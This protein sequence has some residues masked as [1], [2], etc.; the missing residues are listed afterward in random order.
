[1]RVMRVTGVALLLALLLAA[2]GAG[3]PEGERSTT[4]LRL[5]GRASPTGPAAA[6]ESP[7][8]LLVRGGAVA[9]AAAELER[10]GVPV[11][12]W[13]PGGGLLVAGAAPAVEGLPGV[14]AELAWGPDQAVAPEL[15]AATPAQAAARSGGL[16]VVLGLA[17]GSDAM[18]VATRLSAAGAA[19]RWV[20]ATPR[21]VEVGLGIC[22]TGLDAVR[23]H[24]RGLSGLVFAE[25]QPPVR[26]RNAASAWRCQ[27]GVPGGTPVFDRG[28]RGEGQV[29]GLMDTGVDVDSCYFWDQAHGLPALNGRDGANVDLQQ[30]KVL[31]VDF[32]WAEDWPY[33]SSWDWDDQGHGT[34]VAGSA[35]GDA[36]L[37]GVHDGFDG[38]APAAR[39]VI[40]DGGF[41]VD[42]CADL[43]GLGCPTRPLEPVFEQAYLQ[44]ARIHS[45]SWGDEEELT[46]YG[47]YTERTADVDR[48]CW[49]HKDFLVFFAAGN[50]GPGWGTVGSPATGKNVVGVG[51]TVHGS[52]EPP[53][54]ASFSSRGPT[55]DGRLK[56]DVVVPGQ[57]V[58]SARSDGHAGTGNCDVRTSSGTS[59]AAPTAAGLAALVRQYYEDGFYPGR[60]ADPEHG[61]SPSAALVKATLVAAAVDL[62][63]L[64]CSGVERVPS[65]D[66]GWGLVMLERALAFADSSHRLVVDDHRSGFE[67]VDDPPV[68]LSLEV[69]SAGPLKVVLA[70]TD[71]PSTSAAAVNLVNDLDL[72]VSGPDG[73]F[74]GNVFF[75]G[76]S[77][78]GGEPD[79]LNNLEVVWRP[80]ASPGRW[81][82]T[83]TPRAV[84]LGPQDFALV[85]TGPVR[86]EA[87]RAV[88]GRVG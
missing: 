55:R 56:P 87:P 83:V 81:T 36:G 4:G 15:E 8:L 16:P 32:H 37:L 23:D 77:V 45:N 38:M 33:P 12:A 80:E 2:A 22:P 62:A 25:V 40:Q 73:T 30:R 19:V 86:A 17:P 47:R 63:D 57:G 82:V 78:A 51:A 6:G 49:N 20:Q 9:V 41:A 84:N 69:E 5:D 42:D 74:R 71:P 65:R 28:L 70:W 34:H 44:G 64:G 10:R 1:M 13:I 54:V 48:F 79:R 58:V 39:L 88:R 3:L 66:Q 14:V 53:C 75:S 59:M 29:I 21:G 31:A 24:L 60:V 27:G 72:V 61:F 43:P 35:A 67:R 68:M 46:P 52:V 50:E 11:L 76:A 18:A 26:L 85:V 7:R